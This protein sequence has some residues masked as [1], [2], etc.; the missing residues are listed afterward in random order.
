M[1]KL[2][3]LAP[4]MLLANDKIEKVEFI[5]LKH[6][7]NVSAKEIS[8]LHNGEQLNIEKVNQSI[9]N[10]YNMVILKI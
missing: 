9:K 4:L 10:F 3:F 2:L 8:L 5:G 6:I 1:K 7:S